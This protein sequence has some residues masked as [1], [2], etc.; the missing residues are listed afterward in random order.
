MEAESQTKQSA[1]FNSTSLGT[2]KGT[3]SGNVIVNCDVNLWGETITAPHI[4]RAPVQ[5]QT[6]HKLFKGCLMTRSGT[7]EPSYLPAGEVY[8]I[9]D[10]GR[11]NNNTF[12]KLFGLGSGNSSKEKQKMRSKTEGKTTSRRIM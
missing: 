12:Y 8:C 1:L 4:R 10:G 9:T 11:T 7:A 5:Q 6:L 2:V 3:E